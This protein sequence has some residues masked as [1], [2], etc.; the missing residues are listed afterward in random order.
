MSTPTIS[1]LTTVYNR[2]KYLAECIESVQNGHFQDYEHIIVDDGST[3]GSVALAQS[4]AAKDDR[5]RVYQ[6]ETNLG[7]YPNRNQAASY[8]TGKY[9]KYLDADDMHGRF[10]VD[11]MVDAMET[12]PEAGFGLFDYGPDKPLFPILLQPAETYEAHYS[13]RHPVFNRSPLNAIMK[14]N[15]FEEVGGFTG[16][17]MVGDFE[18][19]HVLGA[20]F[21]C[22]VMSAG[23][24][25]YRKHDEQEMT[26]HRADPMWAFKYQLLGLDI[27]QGETCP[28][29]ENDQA[30]LMHK[31]KR[32]LARTVLYSFKSNSIKDTFRLKTAT[33][34]TWAQLVKNAFS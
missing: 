1:I 19:W 18:M 10:M 24:G 32:R 34:K 6:N 5:I 12:F 27:C 16:K 2:E 11:I 30:D 15:V 26:L 21:P 8:A 31:L 22:T 13:G 17:R 28:L 3:D 20:R 7:D 29:A 23:T 33:E 4:Y 14:R 9:I 25:F